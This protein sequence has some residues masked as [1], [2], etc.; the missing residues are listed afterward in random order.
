MKVSTRGNQMSQNLNLLRQNFCRPATLGGRKTHY[1]F[2]LEKECEQGK[3]LLAKAPKSRLHLQEL[4]PYGLQQTYRDE[5]TGAQIPVFAVFDLEGNHQLSYEITTDSVPTTAEPNSLP[6]YL[7]FQK[8]QAF[9]RKINEARVK[10]ERAVTPLAVILG[11]V[12]ALLFLFSNLSLKAGGAA[13]PYALVGGWILGAFLTYVGSLLVLNRICPW[14][15]LVL[16]A[17][18]NGILPKEIREKAR[19]AREE[20]DS[21]Y[22]IV[23]QKHRWKSALLPDPRPRALDPLL[24]GEVKQGR[25]RRFYLIDQFDLTEAEQYLA[26]EF[27]TSAPLP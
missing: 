17:E 14:R 21:L 11:V 8:T 5:A 22:L 4:D 13:I 9:V 7:P 3:T 19:A 20:F 10:A 18:F 24:I 6:S 12:S 1:L 25:R 27:A 16:D 26:D 2:P 23:E 15:K